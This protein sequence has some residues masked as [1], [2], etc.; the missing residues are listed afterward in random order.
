MT[1]VRINPAFLIVRYVERLLRVNGQFPLDDAAYEERY[2]D[3]DP[4]TPLSEEPELTEFNHP[5][6]TYA[7]VMDN[8]NS[9]PEYG[10]GSISFVCYS[11]SFGKINDILNV[12]KTAFERLDESADDLNYFT[13]SN[14]L[15]HGVRF[16][17]TEVSYLEH[18]T[19]AETEGG[20]Q[21]GI[22]SINFNFFVDYDVTTRFTD[23]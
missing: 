11:T 18:G 16:G 13:T 8:N 9:M 22:I 19:P 2:R 7:Y 3:L 23:V 6:L 14:P 21:S 1:N 10:S 4:I 15:Y 20:R 17:S 12:L 5:Y